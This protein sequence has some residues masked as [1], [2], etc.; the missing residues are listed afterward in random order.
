MNP[1]E[2]SQRLF[3]T[4]AGSPETAALARDLIEDARYP[5][6]F[7]L[8]HYLPSAEESE[9]MKA[10]NVL[11]DLRELAVVPLAE[12]ASRQNIDTELWAMRT[13]T[14]ELVAL[15][16]RA[17][18]VLKSLLSNRRPA[19]PAPEGSSPNRT[20][21]GTRVCDLTFI[22]LQRILHLDSSPSAFFGMPPTDRDKRIKEF[23]ESRPFRA[24]FES[25]L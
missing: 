21:P 17:A 5:A 24:A 12:S 19:A 23:Q 7:V 14:E 9:Q 20:P 6:Y 10:K 15:R 22:L 1:T 3:G 18:S 2:F 25:Q 13:M 16:S 11:A 8:Q 4:E